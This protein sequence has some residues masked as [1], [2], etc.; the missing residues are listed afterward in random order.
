[1]G[2]I[3]FHPLSLKGNQ[4]SLHDDV[5]MFLDDA[6]ENQFKQTPHDHWQQIEKGHGRVETRQL[7]CTDQIDW[8]KSRHDWPGLKTIAALESRRRINDIETVERRYFISSL[9]GRVA[10]RIAQAARLHWNIENELHWS[11]DICFGE[12]QSRAR[13]GNAA[14][15]L[16]R[17]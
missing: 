1:M 3:F 7:W 2:A 5:R 13:I 9:P 10:Q 4:S 11:L 17:V 8:L 12:D 16:S 15:N 6:I 14:E